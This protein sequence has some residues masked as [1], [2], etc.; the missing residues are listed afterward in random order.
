MISLIRVEEIG[1]MVP[2]SK[3]LSTL[4]NLV[5]DPNVSM[6]KIVRIVELDMALTAD[7][8]RLANSC[9]FYSRSKINTA[10]EAIVRLGAARILMYLIGKTVST[11]MSKPCPGYEFEADQLWRHSVAA[12]LAAEQIAKVLP[13]RVPPVGF[14]AALLHDI[15]KL[16][17]S[18]RLDGEIKVK[19][20]Q[21]EQN[22]KITFVESERLVLGFDHGEV[23]GMIMRYWGFP[24][25]LAKAV[26]R[27]HYP[28]NDPDQVSD[29]V[30]L[31]NCIA[32]LIGTGL[33]SEAMNLFMSSD[34]MNRMGLAEPSLEA[35]CANVQS[36][37]A[38]AESTIKGE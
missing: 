4:V 9:V 37:L 20:K 35:I 23:G 33:G 10:R 13:G 29:V 11:S 17:L 28:D 5:N 36:G 26:E 12:A 24:E 15:G 22:N 14:T 21:L 38:E 1:E 7:L 27:H 25:S 32:K 8:L 6:N 3:S 31:S 30:H 19:I 34:T 16:L 2:M 18:Q